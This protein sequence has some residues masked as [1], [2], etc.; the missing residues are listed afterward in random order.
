MHES[1]VGYVREWREPTTGRHGTTC[2]QGNC[3]GPIPAGALMRL[4]NRP[5]METVA[6]LHFAL[7]D[8]VIQHL[9]DIEVP[10]AV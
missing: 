7:P 8:R 2:N 4:S 6:R 1:L 3:R 9:K 10:D 5:K